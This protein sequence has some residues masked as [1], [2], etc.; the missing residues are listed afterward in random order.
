MA[1]DIDIEEHDIL[2]NPRIQD[3]LHIKEEPIELDQDL[4]E[5]PTAYDENNQ[6]EYYTEEKYEDQG[7]TDDQIPPYDQALPY[8]QEPPYDQDEP[9]ETDPAEMA[10]KDD[11]D[12][13]FQEPGLESN[14]ETEYIPDLSNEIYHH[15]N[16]IILGTK[17]CKRPTRDVNAAYVSL[18]DW[19]VRLESSHCYC[20][21]CQTLFATQNALDAHN[22]IAHSFLVALD[23]PKN[24]E[25]E[26]QVEPEKTETAKYCDHCKKYFPSDHAL[27]QHLYD[28]I[29]ANKQAPAV[30]PPVKYRDCTNTGQHMV[31]SCLICNSAYLD[32]KWF[33]VHMRTV[34][35][36][37]EIGNYEYIPFT[38]VCKIC[39]ST[40]GHLKRFNHH[41]KAM[42]IEKG[43]NLQ[44]PLTESLESSLVR[45]S[46]TKNVV[47]EL[48]DVETEP[49]NEV[50][51]AEDEV[52]QTDSDRAVSGVRVNTKRSKNS[53]FMCVKCK[54]FYASIDSINHHRRKFHNGER[55]V[56]KKL[57]SKKAVSKVK[58]ISPKVSGTI[59]QKLLEKKPQTVSEKVKFVDNLVPK[60]TIF[61]CNRCVIHFVTCW[62]A[63]LHTCAEMISRYQC[64]VCNKQ[65]RLKDT[66]LHEL[67]H[68]YNDAFNTYYTTKNMNTK[69]L[70]WC[71]KC[72]VYFELRKIQSHS[73]ICNGTSTS[74]RCKLCEIDVNDILTHMQNHKIHST[75]MDFI[76]IDDLL[77]VGE[78][79]SPEKKLTR[80]LGDV[81]SPEKNLKRKLG[82]V[83]TPEKDL[84]RKLPMDSEPGPSK[85]KKLDTNQFLYCDLCLV[86]MKGSGIRNRGH[87]T[88][89]CKKIKSKKNCEFC[90]LLFFVGV[91]MIAHEEFHRTTN[92]KLKDFTFVNFKDQS[93]IVP[94][95]P[96]FPKCEQCEVH[97][98]IGHKCGAFKICKI[99]SK[100]F[101]ETTYKLHLL[102]HKYLKEDNEVTELI[103]KYETLASTWNILYLCKE[104]N[105]CTDTYDD[106]VLHCQNHYNNIQD[107][108]TRNC[109]ICSLKLEENCYTRHK[110]LHCPAITR[111]SFKT[112]VYDYKN[113][114]NEDWLK[115]FGNLSQAEVHQ[116]VTRSIYVTR[117]V[118]MKLILDGPP[119]LTIYKCETC[120]LYID[121]NSIYNHTT[122]CITVPDSHKKSFSCETCLIPFSTVV[123]R[124]DHEKLH[125]TPN[126]TANSFRIVAFN[127]TSDREFNSNLQVE[128]ESLE[129]KPKIPINVLPSTSKTSKTALKRI[130]FYQCRQCRCCSSIAETLIRHKCL[131]EEELVICK[132]CKLSISST[133]EKEHRKFHKLNANITKE[134][135]K[136]VVIDN[137]QL[138]R[139]KHAGDVEETKT[140][141]KKPLYKLHQCKKCKICYSYWVKHETCTLKCRKC[142]KCGYLFS[143]KSYIVHAKWHEQNKNA[144]RDDI[145]VVSLSQEES[146][147][148]KEERRKFLRTLK[149]NRVKDLDKSQ[150]PK[151][152]KMASKSE[153]VQRMT[154]LYQC[155]KCKLC[156][157]S[158]SYVKKH[159]FCSSNKKNTY[160]CEICDLKFKYIGMQDHKKWHKENEGL[161][162][163]DLKVL[164]FKGMKILK[165]KD[166]QAPSGNIVTNDDGYKCNS[167]G[168]T[169]KK[170]IFLN[171]HKCKLLEKTKQAK[172]LYYQCEECE[173]CGTSKRHY[174]VPSHR[175][176]SCPRC[177]LKFSS[178]SIYDHM[179][180]HAQYK[181]MTRG[182]IT[183]IPFRKKLNDESDKPVVSPK[184]GKSLIKPVQPSKKSV[185]SPTKPV[186]KVSTVYRCSCGLHFISQK[187]IE[188]HFTVCSPDHDIP[189]E[190]CSKCGL[191]FPTNHLVSHLCN[192]HSY[193]KGNIEVKTIPTITYY[194][195]GSCKCL[196]SSKVRVLK[197]NKRCDLNNCRRVRCD[198]CDLD[199][200]ESEIT[201]HSDVHKTTSDLYRPCRI[202]TINKEQH[203]DVK[204]IS[205][206]D[207]DGASASQDES[208]SEEGNVSFSQFGVQ[209]D[210]YLYKCKDCHTHYLKLDSYLKHKLRNVCK[211]EEKPACKHCGLRFT[212]ASCFR[213]MY[214]HHEKMKL[215]LED[216]V[217]TIYD[218]K[219]GETYTESTQD[220]TPKIPGDK[221]ESSLDKKVDLFKCFCDAHFLTESNLKNHIY[222][223]GHGGVKFK[224]PECGLRFRKY[225]LEEH[226]ELHH[227][228]LGLGIENFNIV[229]KIDF[230]QIATEVAQKSVSEADD[231]DLSKDNVNEPS[232]TTVIEEATEDIV[233][234]RCAQ[235]NL[236]FTS[237][238]SL[239]N[240]F[241]KKHISDS[242]ETCE[243]C[244][245][246]FGSLVKHNVHHKGKSSRV[247]LI[248]DINDDTESF[249]KLFKCEE[250]NV[251]FLKYSTLLHHINNRVQIHSKSGN[252]IDNCPDCG[253]LFDKITLKLHRTLHH[254]YN[255]FRL[256]DL[257]IDT[258]IGKYRTY[259]FG[260]D[261]N[262]MVSQSSSE[263]VT[264]A[265]NNSLEKSEE[266]SPK[267]N[268]QEVRSS[269]KSPCSS[270]KLYKCGKCNVYFLTQATC[271][272]HIIKHIPMDPKEYIECKLCSFQFRIVSLNTH[273]RKHHKTDFAFDKVLIEE[274]QPKSE[275]EKVPKI[276]IY[277][278]K[279]KVQSRLITTTTGDADD[280]SAEVSQSEID[281]A[282]DPD[283]SNHSKET[284]IIT[285]TDD[286]DTEM[287]VDETKN[288]M[289]KIPSFTDIKEENDSFEADSKPEINDGASNVNEGASNVNEVGSNVNELP[290]NDTESEKYSCGFCS[291]SFVSRRAKD[292]HESL[293]HLDALRDCP[294]CKKSF[295]TSVLNELHLQIKNETFTCCVCSRSANVD[296]LPQHSFVHKHIL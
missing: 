12:V 82:E 164:P 197:H 33:K 87:A 100:K 184:P 204:Q 156:S 35:N 273:I 103:K 227:K 251:H 187:T 159:T 22:M 270:T 283:A 220:K 136:L 54:T 2:D 34:H 167:C 267:T 193:G 21:E 3:I 148:S 180:K 90:G 223:K 168:T 252:R 145:K 19:G 280:N 161:T 67:Q 7:H 248:Q 196:F 114:L 206:D 124:S 153:A 166:V 61:K 130:I 11:Q 131:K 249:N 288:V 68:K 1:D 142:K 69:L 176:R 277:Y 241:E 105:I 278:A 138:V 261:D 48:E 15:N 70:F 118:K 77:P 63:I 117:F 165:I 84:K 211:I 129:F 40:L 88:G 215:N 147:K 10:F 57:V 182:K 247:F 56:I 106:V 240:H 128:A 232:E 108:A 94:L 95:I 175:I 218:P 18:E 80:K 290:S 200:Y 133:N 9:H 20:K 239:D 202:V 47:S 231:H 282:D 209:Y 242:V 214:I 150:S 49:E 222:S 109:D 155:H 216:F 6:Y 186:Q 113:L 183:V 235:C 17:P 225:V 23:S 38:G 26:T 269:S 291:E 171:K 256:E 50:S 272:K 158:L 76:Y 132:K 264:T 292:F 29:T 194:R 24:S 51:Q 157:L 195:C 52:S 146:A 284:V 127:A 122:Q 8:D 66:K 226:L 14:T 174:C 201:M 234:Y 98:F 81:I 221:N 236:H 296:M 293:D 139:R 30:Q 170:T 198:V 207:T 91:P 137:N 72:A 99:C 212:K 276:D 258:S 233:Y 111:D 43:M 188:R 64:D 151:K 250:C 31:F 60:N 246:S 45:E 71:Q 289:V 189:S 135:I 112:V 243:L 86:C 58:E 116:I 53:N 140:A 173:T 205:N 245:L 125:T 263:D 27:I 110:E 257:V 16:K 177:K 162:R 259:K 286:L 46:Q 102:H 5:E 230:E 265:A 85:I 101:S 92:A 123:A 115:L 238:R 39:N 119:E 143:F 83:K 154:T 144:T 36:K 199:F 79:I 78:E 268:E 217:I 254:K 42:H 208:I 178:S 152:L 192:H 285:N 37:S 281:S 75:K 160:T 28:L 244:G 213:H 65:F 126:I 266:S 169:S 294:I 44:E 279:D 62:S 163:A 134:H 185:Q 179:Q 73:K 274:Y 210:K 228:K 93:P 120:K 295:N 104:C 55:S 89:E 96:E 59:L 172:F 149:E 253:L 97:D 219:T 255:S 13:D 271:Y 229:E 74:V 4:Y 224:C 262:N 287:E 107:C 275:E 260:S 190:N 141:I 181:N 41:V 25:P 191:L 237:V 32:I 121:P 203:L